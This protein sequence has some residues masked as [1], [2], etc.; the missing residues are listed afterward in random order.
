MSGEYRTNAEELSLSLSSSDE[1]FAA[2]SFLT[3][4]GELQPELCREYSPEPL[5]EYLDEPAAPPAAEARTRRVR[6]REEEP[7]TPRGGTPDL[8]K[9]QQTGVGKRRRKDLRQIL[10]DRERSADLRLAIQKRR[11]WKQEAR[12]APTHQQVTDQA[13]A[14]MNA[15][16][17][18]REHGERRATRDLVKLRQNIQ[19]LNQ[20]PTLVRYKAVQR[21]RF[22]L[23]SAIEELKVCHTA[24]LEAVLV[25]LRLDVDKTEQE[26]TDEIDGE[27]TWLDAIKDRLGPGLDEADAVLVTHRAL[28]PEPRAGAAAATGGTGMT[29][30]GL[31]VLLKECMSNTAA[32]HRESNERIARE[33]ART[34]EATYQALRTPTAEV[35]QFTGDDSE[36]YRTWK[37]SFEQIYHK[38]LPAN[39]RYLALLQKTGM[40][41]KGFLVGLPVEGASYA[42][43]MDRLDEQYGRPDQQLAR[44]NRLL[45]AEK[46]ATVTNP[47]HFREVFQRITNLIYVHDQQGK[48]LEGAMIID[49]WL[50]KLPKVVSDKWID[51]CLD[52][53]TDGIKGRRG[54]VTAFMRVV[55]R[56]VQKAEQLQE[57]TKDLSA[58]P[59]DSTPKKQKSTGGNTASGLAALPTPSGSKGQGGGGGGK[60]SSSAGAKGGSNNKGSSSQGGAGG[61]T[62]A[63]AGTAKKKFSNAKAKFSC[64]QCKEGDAEHDVNRCR[65]FLKCD[66][67]QKKAWIW[68]SGR[69]KRCLGGGH[70][71]KSCP[72]P[73]ACT[74]QNCKTPQTHHTLLHFE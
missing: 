28:D 51:K 72:S 14:T 8:H 49:Y 16:K 2:A 23:A 55:E 9:V 31:K 17:Y 22:D 32:A 11:K 59:T 50:T 40:P 4:E 33:I 15:K 10:R 53:D 73:K 13:K 66:P 6:P 71:A 24:V 37:V 64:Q 38:G 20:D 26:R 48:P 45:K 62:G 58:K 47:A 60:G 30:E 69:C 41:A 74:K 46:T 5:E 68:D 19:A 63:K 43:G 56:Q 44:L 25:L 1:E 3:A 36:D 12:M 61:G 42:I 21:S 54:D 67:D 57:R 18:T 35:P 34:S 65:E 29:P 39:D 52:A 7:A 27:D 70:M